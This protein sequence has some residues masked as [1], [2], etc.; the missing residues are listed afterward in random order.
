LY[1]LV[2]D[3]IDLP[4]MMMLIAAI[5]LLTLPLTWGL[6]PALRAIAAAHPR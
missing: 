3:L 5:V 1:G 6:R 2:S 4:V